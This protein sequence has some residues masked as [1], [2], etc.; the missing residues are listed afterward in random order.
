MSRLTIEDLTVHRTLNH[1]ESEH[2][3][4]GGVRFVYGNPAPWDVNDFNYHYHDGNYS[5]SYYK[6]SG[7]W[8]S[9]SQF[10]YTPG[11]YY[12]HGDHLHYEPGYW[13]YNQGG[14]WRR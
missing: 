7:N 3:I 12:Q 13:N 9:T 8:H 6:S 5:N 2:I 10:D 1:G 4:G 14:D 11:Y